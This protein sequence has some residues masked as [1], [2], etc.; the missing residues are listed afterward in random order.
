MGTG[1]G[2]LAT[3]VLP[4]GALVPV[5]DA[6]IAAIFSVLALQA[7]ADRRQALVAARLS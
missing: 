6:L 3:P 2:A 4:A 1:V 7:C 5:S